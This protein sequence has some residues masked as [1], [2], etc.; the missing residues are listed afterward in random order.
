MKLVFLNGS[1]QSENRD[2]RWS[3]DDQSLSILPSIRLHDG[4]LLVVVDTTKDTKVEQA[5]NLN[6][7][8]YT[9]KIAGK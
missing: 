8:A 3:D 4:D 6:D 9:V 7:V 2:F 1:L 5:V